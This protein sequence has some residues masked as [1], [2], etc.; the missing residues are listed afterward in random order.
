MKKL[1]EAG[2][3]TLI[4]SPM[5]ALLWEGGPVGEEKAILEEISLRPENW[6]EG[7][8]V[9]VHEPQEVSVNEQRRVYGSYMAVEPDKEPK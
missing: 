1:V 4:R 9:V 6:P 7:T 8:T 5:G 2:K 3:F